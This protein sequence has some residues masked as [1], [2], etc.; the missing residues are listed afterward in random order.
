[1][2]AFALATAG[3]AGASELHTI[4]V[5]SQC[6]DPAR[7]V[8]SDP[9]PRTPPRAKALR[10]NVLLPDGYDGVQEFPVLYLLHGLGG[11]Y[12]YFVRASFGEFAKAVAGLPA[13]VV[14]PEAG[15]AATYNNVWAGGK[16][17]PCWERY[18]LEELIPAIEQ[19]FR[20]R[21]GRRWHAVA[22]FSSG[23]QAAMVYGARR[24]DYF[25]QLLSFS[26][27][28]KLRTPETQTGVVPLV[29][30]ALYA[31]GKLL[32]LGLTPIR[33]AYGDPGAQAFYWAG[34]DPP[35]LAPGLTHSRI[36][37]SHGAPRLPTC[38]DL[39]FPTFRCVVQDLLGGLSE[40][41]FN[42]P[43]ARAFVA[44]ARAAGAEATYRPLTGGHHYPYASEQLG[45][46]IRTWGLFAPVPE[47]PSSWTY[48][49]VSQR[50]R[51]WDLDFRFERPPQA[52]ETFVRDGSRLR[53]TGAG[54]IHIRT[55]GDAELDLTLPFDV[56]L[57][58]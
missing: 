33:D 38:I 50:G 8:M 58:P 55:A 1:M 54:T 13:I 31:P 56:Q 51:M 14:M 10:V 25:G 34:H 44:A 24:P 53:G 22:G 26:G 19:R 7:V 16:R 11:A 57:P 21:P 52:L 41:S 6:V 23:G 12:D 4:T 46:A 40:A 3:P 28:L 30:T 37:A 49:T 32:E 42:G 36:Y 5:P 17:E 48:R 35:V 45:D 15:A 20:V 47:Q 18:Y 27:V 9:P 43:W 2:A 39:L 29:I